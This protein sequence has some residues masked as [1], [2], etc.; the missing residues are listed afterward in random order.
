VSG[1]TTS[2]GTRSLAVGLVL[3]GMFATPGDCQEVADSAAVM[4]VVEATLD[5]ISREDMVAVAGLMLDGA[6]TIARTASGAEDGLQTMTVEDWQR[7]SPAAD[8][9]ERGFDAQVHIDGPIAAVWLPYDFYID[10]ELSHCGIDAFT[11][12]E[13]D[14]EWRIAS[15]AFTRRQPPDCRLHPDGPP[16]E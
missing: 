3:I 11:L 9:V 16:G 1:L 5:A 12:I 2:P 4:A 10:G 15:I 14:Q 13:I 8:F 7:M 6:V